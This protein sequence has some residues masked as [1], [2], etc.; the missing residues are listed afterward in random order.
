MKSPFTPEEQQRIDAAMAAVKRDTSADLCV[1]VT[2]VSDRYDSIL[3]HRLRS[4]RF[5]WAGSSA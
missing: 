1:V 4:P 5:C 3:L 2:R